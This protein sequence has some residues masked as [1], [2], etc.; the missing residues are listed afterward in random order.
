MQLQCHVEC[1]IPVCFITRSIQKLKVDSMTHMVF[2]A[3]PYCLSGYWNFKP[4]PVENQHHSITPLSSVFCAVRPRVTSWL[5]TV[6]LLMYVFLLPT[7]I[8]VVVSGRWWSHI[9]YLPC[10]IRGVVQCP[11]RF[12]WQMTWS[13]TFHHI[14]LC[15]IWLY[16]FR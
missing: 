9:Q 4:I 7:G 16:R 8:L 10:P 5:L 2:R 3:G 13:I 14:L 12:R 11:R 6:T 1:W 15:I